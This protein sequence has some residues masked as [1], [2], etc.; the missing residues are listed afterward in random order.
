MD[1]HDASDAPEP[2]SKDASLAARLRERIRL[3]GPIS[4]RDWMEAA[5]YDSAE[6]YY[7]ARRRTRWGRK[8]DYRTSPERSPL[9][10]ATFAGYF[11]GLYRELGR[12]HSWT[13]IEAGAGAGHFARGLL[14]TLQ[15]DYEEVFRATRYLIDE[16]GEDA[17]AESQQS[18]AQ[19]KERV[20]YRCLSELASPL[21]ACLI[22]SNE[23]LDALPVHRVTMLNGRLSELCVGLNAENEFEWVAREPTDPR[24]S[25]YFEDAGILLEEG[26]V[27]E[28][29]LAA[30]DWLRR[31]ARV[32]GRGYVLT[33]DY[34][35]EAADLYSAPDR[36]E[37][38]LRAFQ[39]HRFADD[40]LAHPGEQDLTTTV[41]WTYLKR[42]GE[43]CGLRTLLFER[44]DQFLLNAGL[45]D[46][47]QRLA[48]HARDE[49]EALILQTG[50]REMILPGGMAAS[51][52]VLV[53]SSS[54]NMPA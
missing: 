50:A 52:Q 10:A 31:A 20:E 33:V 41:D 4:F 8:G 51:F 38:T 21:D 13:I 25:S 47:L 22:F 30:G 24:L 15:R 53:Q 35:A 54:L 43:E 1:Q 49:A 45:L 36:R 42:A 12:P 14:E 5:L 7:R 29:N 28:V 46:Q 23:L 3:D 2:V 40:L 32:V 18:L 39:R 9:F 11:A 26:R 34:G 44:L 6:G 37:G 16:P 17:R 48:A 19:F 27:A